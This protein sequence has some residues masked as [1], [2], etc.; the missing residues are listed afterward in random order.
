MRGAASAAYRR[1]F[2]YRRPVYLPATAH[3]QRT[4]R[5]DVTF[6]LVQCNWGTKMNTGRTFTNLAHI[7][8][9]FR[10]HARAL[11][12]TS[13]LRLCLPVHPT[14]CRR[15]HQHEAD[16][17]RSSAE[18]PKPHR[19]KVTGVSIEQHAEADQQDSAPEDPF[20]RFPDNTNPST[21]EVGG[22]TGPEPTRFG[23]WERKGR[24]TDF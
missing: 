11:P 8:S 17:S 23:D 22:P 12:T 16:D 2:Q 9:S 13:L 3:Y 6:S 24:V 20:A 15:S 1:T 21:G 18:E 5:I 14:S 10:A 4:G 7:G 19:A